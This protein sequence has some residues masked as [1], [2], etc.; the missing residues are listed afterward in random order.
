VYTRDTSHTPGY[1]RQCST[2]QHPGMYGSV[3]P[4]KENGEI[5]DGINHF[6]EKEEVSRR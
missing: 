6:W 5:N 1:V 3:A 2:Y 4:T